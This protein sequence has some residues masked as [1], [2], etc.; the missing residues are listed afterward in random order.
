MRIATAPR[1]AVSFADLGLLLLGCFVML[2]AMQ[3]A[4]EAAPV[5]ALPV[6]ESG[7]TWRAAE[8]FEPGEA[9]LT[10]EGRARLARAARDYR[11]GVELVSRGTG[12]GG[13]RLDRFELSA[14]R[15]A[16]VARALVEGGVAQEDV[17]LRLDAEGAGQTI[18][19]VR[20]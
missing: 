16:A 2:H 4:R 12:E 19:L 7:T 10:E 20:R 15:A 1:W 6:R 3:S 8:L 13:N 14:A 17:A 9:R 18:R 5:H 11:A